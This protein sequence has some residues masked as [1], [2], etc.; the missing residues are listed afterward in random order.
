LF[1][2]IA[3]LNF[4]D[5][6]VFYAVSHEA[7][8]PFGMGMTSTYLDKIIK[9]CAAFPVHVCLNLIPGVNIMVGRKFR[10]FVDSILIHVHVYTVLIQTKPSIMDTIRPSDLGG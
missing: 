5:P 1:D 3:A 4:D 8:T 6:I 9:G 10:C 2:G 7:F